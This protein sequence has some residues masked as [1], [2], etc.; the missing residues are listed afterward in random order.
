MTSLA[1]NPTQ[2][3]G[4][5]FGNGHCVALVRE[6]SGA[7]HT[8]E[9]RPGDP[10]LGAELEPGTPIA[11]F[12][13]DRY[14]NFTDGRSHA[15]LYLEPSGHGFLVIDQ[16]L[17]PDGKPRPAAKRVIRNKRGA[18]PAVDDASRYHVIEWA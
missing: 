18:G 9:W 13:D 12:Q 16:W 1:I 17:G 4:R 14:G 2:H 3:I 15:A 5:S 11:T 8:S 10:V 7:P 6:T